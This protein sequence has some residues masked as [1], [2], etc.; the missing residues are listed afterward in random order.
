MRIPFVVY[1]LLYVMVELIG[2]QI[3]TIGWPRLTG[4]EVATAVVNALVAVIAAVAVLIAADVLFRRWRRAAQAARAARARQAEEELG[5]EVPL[6]V[7]AWRPE[8][9]ALPAGAPPP[10]PAAAQAATAY[11]DGPQG[12][13]WVDAEVVEDV[14]HL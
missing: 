6:T 2:E 12:G 13:D 9:L 8:P 5:D 14:V 7:E 11:V 4:L 3:E 10:D 1:G